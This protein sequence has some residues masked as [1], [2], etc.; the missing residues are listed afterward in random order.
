MSGDLHDAASLEAIETRLAVLSPE[1]TRRWGRMSAHQAVCHL[2]DAFEWAAG[3]RTA[4]SVKGPPLP[5]FLL[6]W[7]ALYLPFPWP[8]G[9]PT[10][11][12]A[13]Q[14]KDGTPPGEFDEDMARL[15]TLAREFS[16]WPSEDPRPPHPIFN[17]M[18]RKGWGRWAY[19]HMDHHLRQFGC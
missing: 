18:S 15:V 2:N 10:M 11:P 7:I 16:E 14:M 13:D 1:S 3:R 8:K 17:E 9:V 19:R 12:S 4:G 5:A 6:R